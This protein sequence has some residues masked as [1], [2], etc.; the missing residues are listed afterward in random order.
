MAQKTNDIIKVVEE[1]L[2]RFQYDLLLFN[3]NYM[4]IT[5][6]KQGLLES[7]KFLDPTKQKIKLKGGKYENRLR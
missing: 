5:Y 1:I 2:K 6:N 3:N 4:K 7:V